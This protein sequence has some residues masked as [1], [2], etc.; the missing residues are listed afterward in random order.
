MR[1]R[2]YLK[3]AQSKVETS[4]YAL[5]NFNGC[6]IKHY[7]GESILPRF[8]NPE[9]QSARTTPKFPESPEFNERINRIRS[10][11]NRAFLDF[12]NTNNDRYPSESELKALIASAAKNGSVKLSFLDYFQDYINR[13][14]NGER[15]NPK[16]KMP[17]RASGVRG[18]QTTLGHLKTFSQIWKR[19]LDFE[20][21][22]LEFH[23]DFTK[24]LTVAPVLLAANTVGSHIQRIKAVL[25]EATERQKNTNMIFKSRYFVKQSEN[26]DTIFLDV[27]E[28]SEL[29][30]LDLSA[31][32]R[33]ENVRDLFLIGCYTGMRFSDFSVLKAE[34][35][36]DKRVKIRQSKTG[37]EVV[38][39]IHPIV[40]SIIEKYGGIIPKALSN[41]KM[42]AYLKEIGKLC[43]ILCKTETKSITKGGSKI[44][45]TVPKWQLLTTHTARRSFATNEFLAGTPT[46]TIMAITGHKT[47]KSFLKYI[48]VTRDQHADNISQLWNEREQKQK[49][50]AV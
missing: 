25:S 11:I 41:E 15:I 5:I 19:K 8:W 9:T 33:L 14:V 38:I 30:A 39:P 18:Y 16:S 27:P 31:I 26:A 1:I 47:E 24:Y 45:L 6:S 37:D 4:I 17:I 42:N 44:S 34:L 22:D 21:I 48:R 32:K 3:R 43:E 13:T 28:L 29:R 35:I 40:S 50:K 46:L 12:R 23:K 10:N 7:T 2:F 20:S 49:S 36:I